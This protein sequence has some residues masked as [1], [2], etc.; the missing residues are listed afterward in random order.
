ML[1]MLCRIALY[2]ALSMMSV[3]TQALDPPPPTPLVRTE[4]VKQQPAGS[5]TEGHQGQP[6]GQPSPA[7]L[8]A[9]QGS[10]SEDAPRADSRKHQPSTAGNQPWWSR[11]DPN[12]IIAAFTLALLW[13]AFTEMRLNSATLKHSKTVE[14]AWVAIEKVSVELGPENAKSPTTAGRAHVTLKNHG[15]LPATNVVLTFT[16]V[17]APESPLAPPDDAIR[18]RAFASPVIAP[19]ASQTN[20]LPITYSK[21]LRNPTFIKVVV[22]YKSGSG[23]GETKWC[24]VV[25]T[26]DTLLPTQDHNDMT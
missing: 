2:V 5:D 12:W 22:T 6:S 25:L 14:R 23:R 3:P 21:D 8:A 18:T 11:V 26:A 9:P 10:P 17:V 19:S 20:T 13:V 24:R 16:D 1:P 4:E 7:S 15:I